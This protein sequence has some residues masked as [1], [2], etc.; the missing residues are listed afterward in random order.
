MSRAALS[1][2]IGLTVIASA[3]GEKAPPEAA[4]TAAAEAAPVGNIPDDAASRDFAEGL[5]AAKIEHFKPSDG[6]G[7]TFVYNTMQFS[8]DNTW[9]AAGYVEAGGESMD[10]KES[11]TWTMDPAISETTAMMTW[12][13]GETD[14]AGRSTPNETRIEVTLVK[15]GGIE[16]AFR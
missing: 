7:A 3:C 10:C 15:G 8:P 5:A 9:T 12:A 2:L 4:A 1:A 13:L 14:C 16:V 6:M 11:G